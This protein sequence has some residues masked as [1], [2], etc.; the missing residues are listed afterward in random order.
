ML[1]LMRNQTELDQL[2]SDLTTLLNAS[3]MLRIVPVITDIP[4][5]LRIGRFDN[6][7]ITF[8][9]V[10]WSKADRIEVRLRCGI[11]SLVTHFTYS[12]LNTT[13]VVSHHKPVLSYGTERNLDLSY[14]GQYQPAQKMSISQLIE[15][16]RSAIYAV[17][18]Y[19]NDS[20]IIRVG[21]GSRISLHPLHIGL[22]EALRASDLIPFTTTPFYIDG[23]L[24][25]RYKHLIDDLVIR[26]PEDADTLHT[27]GNELTY[28]SDVC[29][30]SLIE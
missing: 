12:V 15:A 30:Y 19:P 11:T 6:V 1:S 5:M 9:N 28:R 18:I 21:S 7:T 2:H 25:Q 22:Y 24:Q 17:Y 14:I 10:V 20:P 8:E 27:L 23:A 4:E 26:F 16:I 3:K 13:N 29:Y